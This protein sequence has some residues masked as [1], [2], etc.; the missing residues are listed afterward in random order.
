[1]PKNLAQNQTLTFL[2]I[3]DHELLLDGTVSTLEKYFEGVNVLTSQTAQ[4][5]LAELEKNNPD[6]VVVDLSIPEQAGS[7]AKTEIGLQLLKKIMEKYPNLNIMVQSTYIKALNRIRPEIDNHKGGFTVADKNLPSSE[8]LK[9]AEWALD[10]LT[11]I[12]DLKGTI[13]GL[14][15]KSEWLTVLT[16]AFEEGLQDKAI[17]KEMCV[18]ER[19][20]RHYWSKIQDSLD[21]YPEEGKNMRIQ[22]EKRA[23][24]EGI[25]D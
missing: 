24:E 17:A 6:L 4:T 13:V 3:D 18:S 5:T 12:K 9:R 23:R 21:V 19:M 7:P 14:E 8:M 2:V 1:M 16:L 15:L 25:L 20:V 11:H 22:T 10:G